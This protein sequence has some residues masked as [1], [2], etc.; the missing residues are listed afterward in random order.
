MFR[1]LIM[2]MN[3]SIVLRE[4]VSTE[5]SPLHSLS[6]LI[7]SYLLG[8]ANRNSGPLIVGYPPLVQGVIVRLS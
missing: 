3:N 8:M 7:A 4:S 5:E 1:A 6:V 2:L